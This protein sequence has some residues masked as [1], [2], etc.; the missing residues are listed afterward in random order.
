[1]VRGRDPMVVERFSCTSMDKS[2]AG[3]LT[4]SQLSVVCAHGD[5]GVVSTWLPRQTREVEDAQGT[6]WMACS[7]G[8]HR[9][10]T[11]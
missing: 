10:D 5:K 1:M 4:V 6:Y 9:R 2:V 7:V 8:G 3:P 11:R